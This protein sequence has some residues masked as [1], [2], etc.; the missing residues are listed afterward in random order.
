[1]R[2]PSP[3]R[4]LIDARFRARIAIGAA[5]AACAACGG[6][7]DNTGPP[8]TGSLAI[9][10]AAPSGVATPV[11]VSGPAGFSQSIASTQTIASLAPGS[12]AI[13]ASPGAS[14]D[15]IV[16]DLYAA[17]VTGNPAT[18]AAGATANASVTYASTGTPGHLWVANSGGNAVGGYSTSQLAA[19]G[20]PAPAITIGA[21]HHAGASAESIAIDG[22]G[23]MWISDNS[24][25]LV[26][27][28]AAQIASSTT[29]SP[30]RVLVDASG[31]VTSITGIALDAQG[32]LWLA[33]Q[34]DHV[35]EYSAAQAAVGGTVTPNVTLTS[36]FG[37][38]KR[39]WAVAFDA[40]GNLWVCNYGNNSVASFTPAQIATSGSPQP[41]AGVTGTKGLSGPLGIAFDR[42]GNLW[43]SS[44]IDSL[45]EFPARS[46]TTVGSPAPSVVLARKSVV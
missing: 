46:L 26:Y 30:T 45:V 21:S 5:L 22:S 4:T 16:G 19:S 20:S 17:T 40:H 38:I 43:V 44:I 6:S 18:V 25:S 9:T 32:N 29:A 13:S 37:S 41:S 34:N 12:Y 11:S 2:R 15:P 8:A 3:S 14:A 1:M 39:P 24:D 27:F 10:I 23:G 7:S 35:F 31:T 36:A 33:S 42:N 28:T